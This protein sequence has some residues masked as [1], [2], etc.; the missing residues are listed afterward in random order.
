MIAIEKL[1]RELNI[2]SPY[3]ERIAVKITEGLSSLRQIKDALNNEVS[4]NQIKVVL[5]GMI[6]DELDKII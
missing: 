2:E 1:A 4:Y 3:V 5:A 6:R